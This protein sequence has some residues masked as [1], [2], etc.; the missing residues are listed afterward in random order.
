LLNKQEETT[1][2]VMDDG[3]QNPTIKKDISVLVFNEAIGFGN[4]FL[5]P[6]GP[7]REPKSHVKNAD[8]ILV[9]KNEQKQKKMV[10]PENIPVFYAESKD[11]PPYP[12]GTKIVAFAGIG[13]PKKFFASL[14]DVVAHR[15]FPDHYQY[16]EKD[17]EQL[18]DLAKKKNAKLV[19]TEKDWMRL[20]PDVRKKIKFSK[21]N[22]NIDKKFFTWLKERVNADN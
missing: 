12:K 18:F 2:I 22:L 14:T 6:S 19:T 10:F 9:I 3:F 8:A 17:I 7:L 20:S 13:Y 4:G 15:S 11:V 1:P 16:T 21:L 5:L